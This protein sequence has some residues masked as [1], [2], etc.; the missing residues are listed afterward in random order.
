MGTIVEMSKAELKSRLQDKSTE[1]TQTLDIIARAL[2]IGI[3]RAYWWDVEREARIKIILSK[4]KALR[5]N[6]LT[7]PPAPRR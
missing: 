3:H 4:I 1:F 5:Y 6:K 2:G 7:N